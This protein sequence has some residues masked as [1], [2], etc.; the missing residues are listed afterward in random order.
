MTSG[1]P[2]LLGQKVR[3]RAPCEADIEAR[4][5]LGHDP[6]IAEIFGVTRGELG[7]MTLSDAAKFVEALRAHPYAWV[8][9]ARQSFVGEIRLDRVDFR[10]R[11]ASLA[12]GILDP[13][14]LGQGFGTEAI[15]LLLDHA[16]EVLGLHRLSVRVLAYNHRA[17]RAYQKC[18]FK[19]EGREREAA[20]VNGA[21][22]DDLIMGLLDREFRTVSRYQLT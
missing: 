21:W 4:F 5:R 12:V 19:I 6:D 10:D 8:I 9:E 15:S 16:F 13:I 3:L 14:A 7:E 11:R 2:T 18:G 1:R 17:I 20:F 22:H